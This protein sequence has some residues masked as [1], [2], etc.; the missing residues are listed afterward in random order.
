MCIGLVV[1]SVE[2]PNQLKVQ[3][4]IK[5]RTYDVHWQCRSFAGISRP[6]SLCTASNN[7]P[8]HSGGVN[9]IKFGVYLTQILK[10]KFSG[11]EEHGVSLH[12]K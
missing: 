12:R 3:V 9:V 2:N 11:S 4:R 5:I 1:N 6:Q 7:D 10:G 8:S